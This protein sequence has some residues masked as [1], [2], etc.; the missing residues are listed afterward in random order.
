MQ[1][2]ELF[3]RKF[4]FGFFNIG[5]GNYFNIQYQKINGVAFLFKIKIKMQ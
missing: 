2:M 4:V 3:F 5:N 1:F